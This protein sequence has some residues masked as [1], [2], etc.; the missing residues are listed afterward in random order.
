MGRYSIK[1]LEH[2]SGIKAH[3]IRVWEKRYNLIE[4]QRTETNIRYYSED[5]LKYLLNVSILYQHGLKI[6]TIAK[7]DKIEIKK[8]VVDLSLE[9]VKTDECEL[10]TFISA[11][12]ELDEV[13][14]IN[15]LSSY[16]LKLGFENSIEKILFPLVIRVYYLWQTGT[17]LA[18]QKN[19]VYTLIRQKIAVAIEN[20]TM[21]SYKQ[22]DMRILMF[23]PKNEIFEIE[24]LFYNLIA[25]KEGL[26]VIYLGADVP[27]ND[28]KLINSR[29]KA[30]LI[31]TAF[32]SIQSSEAVNKELLEFKNVFP[33]TPFFVVGKQFE[34]KEISLP[35]NFMLI[36]SRNDFIKSLQLVKYS[37]D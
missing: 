17:I 28:I 37:D 16:I 34:E 10:D 26:D 14:F 15:N 19:F 5:D 3:T 11:M 23:L 22:K 2:I 1:D 7:M 33:N 6:S 18:A 21:S 8:R 36:N 29:K 30:D 4:P 12:L 24:L 27:I 31:V 9:S 13:K 35:V 25:R 32:S 20:E